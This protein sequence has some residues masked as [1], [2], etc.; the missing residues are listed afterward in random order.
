VIEGP[1]PPSL[2]TA[3]DQAHMS[4]ALLPIVQEHFGSR[5]GIENL[6]VEHLERRLIR[7]TVQLFDSEKAQSVEWRLVGKVYGK[8]DQLSY[9]F[10]LMEELCKNGF[11]PETGDG[12]SIAQPIGCL[13]EVCMLLMAEVPGLVLRQLIKRMAA[14]EDQIRQ[15][16]RATVKLHQSPVRTG[17]KSTLAGRLSRIH[18][19]LKVM[20]QAY[21]DLADSVN[22]II[23]NARRFLQGH[24]EGIV[25]LIHGDFHPGQVTVDNGNLCLL[26]LDN[27]KDADPAFDLSHVFSFFKRTARKRKL[28]NYIEGLRD[29]FIA[30]Y[31]SRMDWE[32]ARRIPLYEAL[33]H[34]QRAC[35][36]YRV[37]DETDWEGK[38]KRLIEQAASCIRLMEEYPRKPDFESVVELYC[39]SPGSV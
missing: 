18:P 34:V 13:V 26:D 22:Y 30:E 32:I 29:I 28:S 9:N 6:E 19:S 5:T 4:R 33:R 23:E 36:C 14:T 2:D 3:L 10:G 37:Q 12:I 39:R 31:F 1:F 15:L 21:P 24:G 27:M 11:S 35:K 7:Y 25:T 8:P 16:A 38:M 17:K 20:V